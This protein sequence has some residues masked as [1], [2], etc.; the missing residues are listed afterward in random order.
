MSPVFS[1]S[2]GSV[3]PRMRNMT[4]TIHVLVTVPA[5][6]VTPNPGN[7]TPRPRAARMPM[8]NQFFPMKSRIIRRLYHG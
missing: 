3:N 7:A 2:D 4:T 6:R 8:V 5:L 1:V